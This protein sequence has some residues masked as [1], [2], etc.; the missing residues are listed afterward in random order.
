[1]ATTAATVIAAASGHRRLTAIGS[2]APAAATAFTQGDPWMP[3]LSAS[4]S[5]AATHATTATTA[6]I[7]VGLRRPAI[8]RGHCTSSTVHA[9]AR[10]YIVRGGYGGSS[11]GMT[12]SA[13]DGH[14][15]SA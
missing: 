1:M 8:E 7:A 15:R 6:S 2:V 14:E 5:S 12:P 10:N 3:E 9:R 11:S 13:P 4:S